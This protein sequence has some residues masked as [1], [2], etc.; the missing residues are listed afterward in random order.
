MQVKCFHCSCNAQSFGL[1]LAQ[2]VTSSYAAELCV[3]E[4]KQDDDDDDELKSPR[5][6]L[7]AVCLQFSCFSCPQ[8]STR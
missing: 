8:S 5:L 7:S 4:N 1:A 6:Q 2:R 3:S